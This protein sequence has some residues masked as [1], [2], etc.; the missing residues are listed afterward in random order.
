MLNTVMMPGA[1]AKNIA[2]NYMDMFTVEHI[3]N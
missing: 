2:N 3:H 1:N